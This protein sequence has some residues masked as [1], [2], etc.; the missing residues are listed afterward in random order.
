M[1]VWKSEVSLGSIDIL[2]GSVQESDGSRSHGGWG[3][4]GIR[5][6]G[7]VCILSISQDEFSYLIHPTENYRPFDISSPI[8]R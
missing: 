4:K 6:S 7:Y 2:K 3:N 5:L 1:F 8:V